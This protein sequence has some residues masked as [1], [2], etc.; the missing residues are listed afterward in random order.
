MMWIPLAALVAGVLLGASLP[1]QIPIFYG[2]YLSVAL[3]AALDSSFGGLR[4][5]LEGKYDNTVF[6]SG[7]FLNALLAAGLTYVG[8]R[9]GVELY[10]AA[11]VAFGIRIFN[12]LGAIRHLLLAA[13]RRRSR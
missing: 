9:L 5:V 8:D 7:F 6:I 4:A 11:L 3:L 12:N 2:R 13:W 10:F 1:L